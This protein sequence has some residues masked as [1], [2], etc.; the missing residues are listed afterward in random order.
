MPHPPD[1]REDVDGGR[2]GVQL[3]SPVVRYPDGREAALQSPH[4]V[5][6]SADPLDS[7]GPLPL[8]AQPDGVL[9]AEGGIYLVVD[10]GGEAGGRDVFVDQGV[11]VGRLGEEVPRPSWSLQSWW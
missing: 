7:S 5:L 11:V 6:G 10:E 2:A 3:A 1:L 9:P 4:S 8:L